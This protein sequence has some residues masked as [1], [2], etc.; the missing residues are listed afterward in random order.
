[1]LFEP[2]TMVKSGK[3]KGRIVT[4]HGIMAVQLRNTGTHA[5]IARV[6]DIVKVVSNGRTWALWQIEN[7][8]PRTV[9]AAGTEA[10]TTPEAYDIERVIELARKAFDNPVTKGVFLWAESGRVGEGFKT[11]GEF[12]QWVG[13]EYT[14]YRNTDRWVK[15][16]QILVADADEY[17]TPEEWASFGTTPERRYDR[18]KRRRARRK[19]Q[20][21]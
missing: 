15:G 4:H 6:N 7:T 1:M 8:K 14:K 17:I 5:K 21:R 13:S 2:Q 3:N 11:L 18:K 9:K 10:F 12:V 16:I 19:Q 20:R